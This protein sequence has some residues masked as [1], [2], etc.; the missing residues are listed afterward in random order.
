MT[1]AQS[2][3]AG[4]HAAHPGEPGD[5]APALTGLADVDAAAAR[6]RELADAEVHVHPAIFEDVHRRLADV[7]DVAMTADGHEPAD[8]PPGDRR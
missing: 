6:L 1:P 2:E 8:H 7:L 3:P 5:T 4:T